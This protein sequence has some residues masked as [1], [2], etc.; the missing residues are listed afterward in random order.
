MIALSVR[1]FVMIAVPVGSLQTTPLLFA[2]SSPEAQE[3]V[4][5]STFVAHAISKVSTPGVS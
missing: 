4:I 3:I 2:E 1:K 5:L